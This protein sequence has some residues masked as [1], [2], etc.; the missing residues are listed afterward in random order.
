MF[1]ILATIAI[2]TCRLFSQDAMGTTHAPPGSANVIYRFLPDRITKSGYSHGELVYDEVIQGADGN[3]YGTTTLGGSGL[4]TGPF[5]VQGC[6]TVFKLTPAGLQTVI[7]NFALDSS[8]TTAVNGIY[9]YGGLVQGADGNFYGT[10]SAGGNVSASCNGY[11]LGCGVIFKLTPAGVL[12]VLHAFNGSLATI[13]DGASPTGRLLL[14]KDGKFYGTTY[15]GGNVQS[16][17][18]QGTIFSISPSGTYSTL[19]MFDNVHGITDGVNPYAGLIQGKDGAFYGTTYFGGTSN[20]GTVFKYA[21]GKTTVLHSFPEQTGQFFSDG[22]YPYAALVQATDGNF[23]G[24]TSYGGTLTTFYQSGTVFRITKAGTFTKL[25]DFNSTNATVNGID[26]YGAFIQA[27]DGNLYGT[28][29]QGGSANAGTVFQMTLGGVLTQILSFDSVTDGAY[30]RSVP[31]QAS[32]GTL[33]ITTSTTTNGTDQGDVIQIA[34]GLAAP[35][36]TII[37]F[38]PTSAK[39]GKTVTITGTHF[40]GTTRVAFNGTSATFTIRSTTS[41]VATVPSGAT[42]GPIT[43]TNAGGTATSSTSFTVL[44]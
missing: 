9:P 19:Y 24:T 14:A 12:K 32:D 43:V 15:D 40:V 22:A 20:A 26:G 18:N 16:F 21:A 13:P 44:P 38:A 35:A 11:V 37:K 7:Y 17:F 25:W 39:V 8:G 42:T 5:G 28:T 34:N 29:L 33:Y 23:Y 27:S 1:A 10:A 31:L 30:P 4:C 6:G 36:P 2:L 3:F 41:M